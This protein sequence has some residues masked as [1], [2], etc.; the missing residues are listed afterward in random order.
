MWLID[1]NQYV[2]QLVALGSNNQ[3]TRHRCAAFEDDDHGPRQIVRA[4]FH[5]D[6]YWP[7]PPSLDSKDEEP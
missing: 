3:L 7:P 1:F 2:R 4:F 6:P 5:N